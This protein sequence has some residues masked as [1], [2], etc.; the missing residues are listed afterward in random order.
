MAAG[1]GWGR[2]RNREAEF[3]LLVRSLVSMKFGQSKV[4]T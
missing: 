3:T 1:A 4:G 2:R